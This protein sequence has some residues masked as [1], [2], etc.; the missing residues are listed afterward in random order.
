MILLV[1]NKVGITKSLKC[2]FLAVPIVASFC[3][4]AMNDNAKKPLL[5]HKKHKVS[6]DKPVL[7]DDTTLL[8]LSQSGS[9][10]DFKKWIKCAYNMNNDRNLSSTQWEMA[11]DFFKA[12]L[13]CQNSPSGN[14]PLHYAVLRSSMDMSACILW[15]CVVVGV[16]VASLKNNDGKTP[17]DLLED[18][19]K[20]NTNKKL[21]KEYE[22]MKLVFNY[23]QKKDA[24]S[25]GNYVYTMFFSDSYKMFF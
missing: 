14:T 16:D 6:Q 8:S 7:M 22:G 2:I 10:K 17:R 9:I 15:C 18:I 4:A 23:A 24:K 5:G 1:I 13:L 25:L 11:V 3:M 12:S 21:E 20:S 19:I